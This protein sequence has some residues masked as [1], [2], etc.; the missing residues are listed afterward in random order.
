M[1]EPASSLSS[2]LQAPKRTQTAMNGTQVLHGKDGEPTVPEKSSSLAMVKRRQLTQ[3][4]HL[5][6]RWGTW[7]HPKRPRQ[8]ILPSSPQTPSSQRDR[9]RERGP[10]SASAL[11]QVFETPNKSASTRQQLKEYQQHRHN[12]SASAPRPRTG[13]R[14]PIPN[15]RTYSHTQSSAAK[16]RAAAAPEPE[17]EDAEDTARIHAWLDRVADELIAAEVEVEEVEAEVEIC[18]VQHAAVDREQKPVEVDLVE[19]EVEVPPVFEDEITPPKTP[20]KS[21]TKTL[22]KTPTKTPTRPPT[23][24]RTPTRRLAVETDLRRVDSGWGTASPASI[25]MAFMTPRTVPRIDE[26]DAVWEMLSPNVTPFRKGRG[27]K[28]TRR[29]SYYDEDIWPSGCNSPQSLASVQQVQ[30]L[31]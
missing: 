11:R 12:K 7:S 30:A 15:F 6:E 5:A 4:T 27:P 1:P 14:A 13:G 9:E 18:D 19:R 26:D 17:D 22:T 28:R 23:T 10:A 2:M 20:T 21:P 8:Q 31:S 25:S 3:D 16:S 24:T 29:R